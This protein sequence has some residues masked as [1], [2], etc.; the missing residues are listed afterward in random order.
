MAEKKKQQQKKQNKKTPTYIKLY[1]DHVF[2][3]S[4]AF[5]NIFDS[6]FGRMKANQ[7]ILQYRLRWS[8]APVKK[9][10]HKKV[11]MFFSNFS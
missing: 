6:P 11:G 9:H 4:N 1:S 8:K 2:K 5:C 10:F 7:T 3:F